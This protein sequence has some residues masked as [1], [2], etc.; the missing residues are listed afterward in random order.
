LCAREHA[1]YQFFNACLTLVSLFILSV[2][3]SV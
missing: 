2:Q 1:Y 3:F